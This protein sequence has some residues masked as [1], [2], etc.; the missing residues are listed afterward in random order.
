MTADMALKSTGVLTT[1]PYCG[2]GCGTRIAPGNEGRI[3]VEGDKNHPSNFGRLCSKGSAL[4]ETLSLD[5]RLLRPTIGGRESDWNEALSLVAEKFSSTIAAHGPDSVAFYVSGQLLTEDYYI[6]NKLMK[7]FIGSANI[8]TNSRLCMSSSVAGMQRAFGEDV[9]PGTYEDFDEADLA[10]IVGSNMAWCHPILF[11]RLIAAKEK[12]NTKIIVI[13]PRATATTEMSDLHLAIAPGSDVALFNLLLSEL[14]RRGKADKHYIARHTSGFD[15]A[16]A[17]AND[18][19]FSS[20]SEL[21]GVD[22]NTLEQFVQAFCETERTLTLFSQGV[23]QSTAGTDKVNAIINCH[24]ATGRIGKPGLGPFSLTGQPNAMGG[25][26]VGGMSSTLAC[27]MDISNPE[28]R[29]TAQSFWNSPQMASQPGLKA[30]DLMNSVSQGRVKALWIMATSPAD[31]MPDADFVRDAISECPFV[32]VSDVMQKTGTTGLANVCLPSLAWGEKDGTVTNSERRI[33]R[34]RSFMAAPGEAQPD[35]WQVSEVAK[36]MGFTDAFSYQHASEIF[37][38]YAAMSGYENSGSRCF[39]ISRYADIDRHHYNDLKPFQWPAPK[40]PSVSNVRIFSDGR[41]S[42]DDGKARFIATHFRNVSCRTGDSYPLTMN[43][44]RVRDQWHTMTRTGKSPRLGRH[45]SEPF[46]EVHPHDAERFALTDACLAK[47]CSTRGSIVVRTLITNRQRQGS[48]FVPIHWTENHA[49]NARVDV[50][51]DP[52]VDPVSGQPE[53]K[54]TPIKIAA[55]KATSFA[56]AVLEEKPR[57]LKADYWAIGPVESGWRV[58]LAW[59]NEPTDW[60]N[61]ASRLFGNE[62]SKGELISYFD[63]TKGSFR[64]AAFSGDRLSSILFSAREPVAV[65]RDMICN[66]LGKS[67]ESPQ[68]RLRLLAGKAAA[69]QRD[70]GPIICSCF[71]VGLNDIVDAVRSDGCATVDA[72]GQSLQAGTNCGSCRPELKRIIHENVLKKAV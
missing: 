4:G 30:V 60:A 47:V 16:F 2:V 3:A 37:K 49:S 34:Q 38:E 68:Q 10:V 6:A 36:R 40:D 15:A 41:F 23:N 32:V 53:F 45:I 52:N 67:I 57:T 48:V 18:M 72:I 63:A 21:T 29:R 56:F 55:F 59:L 13:D 65:A 64:A 51:V 8:D 22:I 50:L 61:E 20:C 33:S 62:V 26:E 11:Q 5:G 19:T 71:G 35:W 54:A 69:D 31:S 58:E 7:G 24:L 66:V 1:C 28:H 70:C 12:R 42:T 27:H 25:R 17:I 46:I 9:V 44:G 14:V 39:D 43:T